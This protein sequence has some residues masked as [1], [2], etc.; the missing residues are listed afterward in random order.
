MIDFDPQ[1]RA[2][3]EYIKETIPDLD[4]K[5]F[6]D[7]DSEGMETVEQ[8]EDAYAGNYESEADFAEELCNDCG[9]LE[10]SNLPTFI[11]NHI[12]W[13]AV[14]DR[15]LTHDYTSIEHNNQIYFFS[16]HF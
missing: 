9:Y 10:E 14:W 5:L 7:I 8:F 15:E 11:S 4:E 16:R 3:F 1:E 12:D 13:Q 6:E 2:L